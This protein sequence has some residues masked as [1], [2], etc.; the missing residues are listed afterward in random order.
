ME[1]KYV[2]ENREQLIELLSLCI[3]LVNKH[4]YRYRVYYDELISMAKDK[5]KE[6]S[7]KDVSQIDD[8][9]IETEILNVMEHTN[10]ITNHNKYKIDYIEYKS[11]EDK[12]LNVAAQLLN[13]LGDRTKKGG[14][15]YWRFRYEYKKLKD[16][17]QVDLPELEILSQDFNEILNRMYSS[18]NY[19]HHMTDA[20][21]IEWGNYRKKQIKDNPGAFVKWPDSVIYSERYEYVSVEWLWQLVHSQIE[22]KKDVR[23]ILQQMKKDYSHIYGERMR[24]EM[25]WKDEL[26]SEIFEVSINGINRHNG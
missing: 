12:I 11:M 15:S 9:D 16:E 17:K 19:Q 14:V 5:I 18:R 24:V 25:P 13:L 7:N 4:F 1:K 8:K 2:F 6:I 26:T 20:K 21:F 10:Y 22:F 23:E 3:E